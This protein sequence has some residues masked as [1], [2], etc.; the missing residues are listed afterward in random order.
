MEKITDTNLQNIYTTLRKDNAYKSIK[1]NDLEL[2]IYRIYNEL[3][4]K[5]SLDEIHKKKYIDE[6]NNILEEN[7]IEKIFHVCDDGTIS[8]HPNVFSVD[9][10]AY[11][12]FVAYHCAWM[13]E[14][15][16]QRLKK[17][18]T[19]YCFKNKIDLT[20]EEYN[21]I[22]NAN[23]DNALYQEI[24]KKKILNLLG[25]KDDKKVNSTKLTD[26]IPIE[27]LVNATWNYYSNNNY[28]DM[29][30]TYK[31]DLINYIKDDFNKLTEKYG[32]LDIIARVINYLIYTVN[33]II[34]PSITKERIIRI[35]DDIKDNHA[36]Y[37]G[38]KYIDIDWCIQNLDK[39]N[40]RTNF[41]KY[42]EN[43]FLKEKL[44]KERKKRSRL[45]TGIK[46]ITRQ[47]R[48]RNYE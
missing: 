13:L 11:E 1:D 20:E 19:E 43:K 15:M 24:H 31:C 22:K 34:F 8:Y 44:A 33:E 21:S 42:Y 45:Q 2:L 47:K 39:E 12:E 4:P 16:P 17:T 18:V 28:Y 5:L 3:A 14:T 32:D 35:L 36:Y 48:L 6:I 27:V 38:E 9:H 29:K 46:A 30:E 40:D 26:T 10:K 23:Y 25:I 41:I 7:R 37:H